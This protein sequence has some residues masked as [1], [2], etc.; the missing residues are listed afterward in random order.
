[1]SAIFVALIS[2]M[3][4]WWAY[5]AKQH[6]KRAEGHAK[7]GRDL[8]ITIEDA[9]N[10]RHRHTDANGDSPPRLFDIALDN[11]EA[12]QSLK[13]WQESYQSEGGGPLDSGEKVVE[14]LERN[15]A[16]HAAIFDQLGITRP[17]EVHETL[18]PEDD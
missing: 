4:A 15:E 11:R 2:T 13:E 18:Y 3:G 16:D 9:V 1:M 5:Q 12:L 6:G 7:E 17:P 10:H 14:F 8:G